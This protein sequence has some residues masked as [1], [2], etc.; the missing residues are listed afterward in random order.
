MNLANRIHE[1]EQPEDE[2]EWFDNRL[3]EHR[4]PFDHRDG[5]PTVADGWLPTPQLER[6]VQRKG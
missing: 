2:T 4:Q 1:L 3:A 5:I 6:V